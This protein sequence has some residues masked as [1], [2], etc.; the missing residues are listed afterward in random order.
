MA[1]RPAY[2][3]DLDGTLFSL[4]FILKRFSE[5]TGQNI[6]F[7]DMKKYSLAE[8]FSISPEEEYSI[9]SKIGDDVN[10]NSKPIQKTVDLIHRLS[11]NNFPIIIITARRESARFETTRALQMAGVHYD[12]IFMNAEEKADIILENNIGRYFDDQGQLIEKMMSHQVANHCELTLV[13]APYNQGYR[14][15]SRLYV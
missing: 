9:F 5:I 8:N 1:S 15:D 13:D 2:G 7:E 4:K 10:L 12:K 6:Q 3:F 11:A 14:C